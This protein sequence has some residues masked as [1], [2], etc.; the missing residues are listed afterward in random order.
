MASLGKRISWESDSAPLCHSRKGRKKR[1]GWEQRREKE[2]FFS[3]TRSAWCSYERIT[4]III[5]LE[6]GL[7]LNAVN[8]QS[9]SIEK[10]IDKLL[11]LAWLSVSIRLALAFLFTFSLSSECIFNQL[12]EAWNEEAS[13]PPWHS[14]VLANTS[15]VFR[16]KKGRIDTTCTSCH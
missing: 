1:M 13:V 10:S 7:R 9:L 3:R 15:K 5:Q 14:H 8:P 2:M 11:Q 6:L 4:I 12:E 16:R